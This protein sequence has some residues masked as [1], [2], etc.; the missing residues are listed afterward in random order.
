RPLAGVVI[1]LRDATDRG[2]ATT[3]TDANGHYQFTGLRPGTYSLRQL[4]PEGYFQGG[5]SAG[6]F[7]GDDSLEDVIAAIVLPG[8]ANAVDYDFAEIP[9]GSISG[10]VFQDGAPVPLAGAPH[11]E[12]LRNYQ[13][14]I[15]TPDDKPLPGVILQ[16]RDAEGRPVSADRALAGIYDGIIQVVT[17]SDGFYQF[18]GLPPGIYHIYQLQPDGYIDGLDTPGTTGGKAVNAGDLAN[19]PQLLAL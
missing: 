2:I 7:G 3:Q 19:A 6:N 5:Q 16:L 10:Y 11:P 4:Q 1:E 15:R 9:P 18:I 13:D 8:G 12:D 14:G 17:D